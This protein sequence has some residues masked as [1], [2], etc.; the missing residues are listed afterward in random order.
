MRRRKKPTLPTLDQTVSYLAVS[1]PLLWLSYMV[2]ARIYVTSQ[3]IPHEVLLVSCFVLLE[4]LALKCASILTGSKSSVCTL[5]QYPADSDTNT[6]PE[7]TVSLP[8]EEKH[9]EA[10]TRSA[11]ESQ[12][13]TETYRQKQKDAVH[14]YLYHAMAPIL[15]QEDM[16]ALWLEYESWI[17]SP[18]YRPIGRQ[19][20]WKEGTN[21]RHLDVRHLTWNIAKRLGLGTDRD[22]G[23]NT[24]VCARFIKQL[25]PDLCRNVRDT[26]LS[27]CLNADPNEGYVKIDVPD[28]D[29]P[30]IFHYGQP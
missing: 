26:T 15:E 10:Y 17:D 13:S 19:W 2:A 11:A 18:H 16:H 1:V 24:V 8:E 9:L 3:L 27:Q 14:E 30:A 29:N 22:C 23:Y 12:L 28:K 4:S 20:K 6:Q 5:Y 21:V 25:F 7:R